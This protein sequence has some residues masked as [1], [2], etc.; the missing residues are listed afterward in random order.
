MCNLQGAATRAMGVC[1]AVQ[2]GAIRKVSWPRPV[3]VL[4]CGGQLV[5]ILGGGEMETKKQFGLVGAAAPGPDFLGGQG[6]VP[7]WGLEVEECWGSFEG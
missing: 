1:D 4:V 7:G 6:V 3:L 5:Q 2:N